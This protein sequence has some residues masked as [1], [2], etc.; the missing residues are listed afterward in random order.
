[1]INLHDLQKLKLNFGHFGSD[2]I[3]RNLR[4]K[5]FEGRKNKKQ[6]KIE[7]QWR[8]IILTGLK[9]E[10]FPNLYTDLSFHPKMEY[11]SDDYFIQL[12]EYLQDDKVKKHIMLFK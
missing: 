2:E 12:K 1:M 3:G 11:E 8:E 6:A 10:E 7:S 5:G 4:F 9:N